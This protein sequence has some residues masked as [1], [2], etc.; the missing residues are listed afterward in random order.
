MSPSCQALAL[1][2]LYHHTLATF[3]HCG[4]CQVLHKCYLVSVKN[5]HYFCPVLHSVLLENHLNPCS[6]CSLS[7]VLKKIQS[8]S[9]N[10]CF[11]HTHSLD[12]LQKSHH[13]SH[14]G[15]FLDCLQSHHS[16]HP[17][18]PNRSLL[19][20]HPVSRS[21]LTHPGNFLG[22]T[23]QSHHSSHPAPPNCSLLKGHPV[24]RSTPHSSWQLSR[25]L[26]TEPPLL[27]SCSSRLLSPEGPPRLEISPHSSPQL[28][29]RLSA[30]PLL[31]SPCSFKPISKG[32]P[33]LLLH[34][35]SHCSSKGTSFVSSSVPK[36]C[37]QEELVPRSS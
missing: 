35:V 25:R 5:H 30:E 36:S 29:Q 15:N 9:G 33:P 24:S 13:C 20:G 4:V 7:S 1:P 11:C 17:D 19:K 3:H 26:S 10:R 21:H 37:S 32:P 16:S 2:F 28:S 27:S 23:L 8:C 18:P 22:D 12:N 34:S 14:P 6:Y 31:L